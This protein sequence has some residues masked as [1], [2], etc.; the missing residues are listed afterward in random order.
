MPRRLRGFSLALFLLLASLLV[1][2]L[3]TGRSTVIALSDTSPRTGTATPSMP[4]DTPAPTPTRTPRPVTPTPTLP[5]TGTIILDQ[6]YVTAYHFEQGSFPHP[7]RVVTRGSEIYLLDTGQVKLLTLG[8]PPSWRPI[9]PPNGAVEGVVVHEVADIAL[10]GDQSALLVL[11]RAGNLFRYFPEERRWQVERVVHMPGA[12]SRQDL[13]S[14]CAYG[15]NIYLL[16]T[17]LGQIW[18]HGEGQADVLPVE[19]ELRES[20]DFAVGEDIFVLAEQGYRGPVTLQKL[21]GR[22]LEPQSTFVPPSDL[23]TPSLLFLD[24][25]PGGRL[26]V[27]DEGYRRLRSLDKESGA[28]VREYL[29]ADEEV[30]IRSVYAHAGKLYLAATD[31]IYVHPQQTGTVAVEKPPAPRTLELSSLPPHDSAVLELLP[32]FTLPIEE[33]MLSN[34]AFRLPGAPRSYRYGVHEGIDFYSAAGEAV[35][36]DT[37]VLAIGEGTI[38]RADQDYAAP[39][40]EEMEEMLAR[41]RA[42]TYTP[43]DTLDVLRGRQVWV[44]HGGGLVS[45]YCH[46]SA[47]ADGVEPGQRVEQ[48]QVLGRV[49][50]SGTPA[51][52]YDPGAEMHLHLEIRIGDGY[53]G[54]YLRPVEVK[55]WLNRAFGAGA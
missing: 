33:T 47:V 41:A 3:E 48:G 1:A 26:Y 14:V 40:L 18:R 31:T 54:Q 46:L 22:P 32:T 23:R 27:I 9:L 44:D 2:R 49:G 12:S 25:E 52:Y 55:R 50:N 7:L 17:N 45:R 20:A 11:D 24:A 15:D 10:S 6:R 39:T 37:P 34:M 29:F 36:S 16:D 51:S 42:S 28:L 4:T 38:V 8:V 19:T 35:T 13:I 43:P 21:S 5:V 30:E 53:L